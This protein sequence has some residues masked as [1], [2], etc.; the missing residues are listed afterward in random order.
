[1]IDPIH[2]LKHGFI[3]FEKP[4]DVVAVN[5]YLLAGFV[6]QKKRQLQ[7]AK[8]QKVQLRSSMT[9]VC[10]GNS[11]VGSCCLESGWDPC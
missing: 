1:M 2:I 5:R 11:L 3:S 8:L 6:L 4:P 7:N 9:T 10:E